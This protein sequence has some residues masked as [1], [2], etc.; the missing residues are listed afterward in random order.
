MAG[1]G[2]VNTWEGTIAFPNSARLVKPRGNGI[3]MVIDKGL[4]LSETANLLSVAGEYVDYIKLAFGTAA[5]YPG[6]ILREKVSFIRSCGIQIYP[7]GTFMEIAIIQDKIPEFLDKCR[8]LGF[9]AIEVSDGT[10]SL[11]PDKRTELIVMAKKMGFTVLSEV[12]KKSPLESLEIDE[13]VSQVHN[14]LNAGADYVIFEARDSGKGIGI[15]NENGDMRNGFF[16]NLIQGL[17]DS[18]KI[19]WEAPLKNQQHELIKVFGPNVNLG[20]IPPADVI[21]LESLRVGLRSDTLKDIL[22][23]ETSLAIV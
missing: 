19:I 12:G 6:K 17:G 1:I 15:F 4:G 16:I 7:G 10:I 13:M 11:S 8:D 2:L 3:T 14:D 22:C 20:N 23:K 21:A 5:L 9:S 18:A